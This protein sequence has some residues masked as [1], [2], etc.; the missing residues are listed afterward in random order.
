MK[1]IETGNIID[2][3]KIL[4]CIHSGGMAKIFLVK[5]LEPKFDFEM[6]M[7]VPRMSVSDGAENLVS[8][9]VESQIMPDLTGEHFP[10]LVAVGNLSLNPYLVMEYIHGKT[11]KT[12][13]KENT[14]PSANV[15][16]DLGLSIAHAIH[17]LHT[18]NICHLDLKPE[19]ILIRNN[20]KVVLLDFG[21]SY[22]AHYPDLLAEEMRKAIGSPIWIAPEQVVG[23]RGDPRSDIFSLGV[24]LYE[25]TTKELPY[26]NPQTISGLRQRLWVAPTPPKNICK[27]TP[28][29]L[30]EII[31]RCLEPEADNRYPSAAHLALDL[32]N[33]DQ[34][35]ITD[36]GKRKTGTSIRTHFYRWIKA[37]GMQYKPSPLPSLQINEVPIIMVALPNKDVSD[38]TLYSLKEAVKRSLGIRPGARLTCVT[39][40]SPVTPIGAGKIIKSEIDEHLHYLNQMRDWAKGINLNNHQVTFHVL[41]A[42]NIARALLLYADSNHVNMIITGAATHGIKFQRVSIP[43]PIKI[44][45]YAPCTV[46]LVKQDLP[47]N[48]NK[49][50]SELEN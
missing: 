7:K 11:L 36:R 33:H 48:F 40:I 37:A 44:A 10:R 22:H 15:I 9:E 29:W 50:F 39:V 49:Q 1:P 43:I 3:F 23:V 20:G 46:I 6:V 24:I 41:E 27:S 45:M 38:A 47:F 4:D 16:A 28:D 18:Q 2:G 42:S 32:S 30:Q 26:G 34:I 35:V 25:L 8:F 31:L 12:W 19:N 21:L 5:E 17:S 13:M 14:N